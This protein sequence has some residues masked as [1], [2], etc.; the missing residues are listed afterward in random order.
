MN[1]V[2]NPP[3]SDHARWFEREV[4]PHGAHLKTYLEG[5]FP[6]VRGDVDDIV[7]ESFLRVWRARAS[8]PVRSAKAFLF[9]VGRRV[10]LDLVRRYR[11]SPVVTVKDFDAILVTG[12]VSDGSDSSARAEHIALLVEAI[13]S[14]PSRCREIFVLCHIED[15]SQ[16]VVAERLGLS[17]GTIGVQS[18][19]GLQRCEE[20]IRQRLSPP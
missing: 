19:R 5:E 16:K 18:A 9:T 2:V 13:Q 11:R 10:A 3:E 15:L 12:E 6:S 4:E 20:F 14:L 17:I 8:Q 7:Q 1:G